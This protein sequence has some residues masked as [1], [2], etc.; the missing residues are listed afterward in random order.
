ML[1]SGIRPSQQHEYAL[2]SDRQAFDVRK[3][4]KSD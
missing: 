1:L 4:S 3:L 2:A